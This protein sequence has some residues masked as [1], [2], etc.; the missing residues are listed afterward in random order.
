LSKVIIVKGD[1]TD[2]GAVYDALVQ[3]NCDAIVNSAGLAALF[4]FQEPR[5]QG[6]VNAV[7]AAG[8]NASEKLGRPLRS[9]FLG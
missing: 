2:S 8:V 5:M 3:N 1:A 9:W 6:I 4:S 7:S